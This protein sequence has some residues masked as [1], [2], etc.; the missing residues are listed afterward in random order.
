[1]GLVPTGSVQ[2][3]DAVFVGKLRRGLGQ[4]DTYQADIDPRQ[5]HRRYLPVGETHGNV[6]VDIFADQLAANGGPQG[7]RRPTASRVADASE[8][9]L[10]LNSTHIRMPARRLWAM[11]SSI[12]G[13]FLK[14]SASTG[15]C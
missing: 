7:Q 10:V 3:H 11:V 13:V 1:M 2:K 4:K 15:V 12:S 9:S 8:T 14:A 6:C 5:N